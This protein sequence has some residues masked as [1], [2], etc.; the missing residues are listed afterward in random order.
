MHYS[1]Y[2]K[3]NGYVKT[4][5]PKPPFQT[6]QT[7]TVVDNLKFDDASVMNIPFEPA[8]PKPEPKKEY[9]MYDALASIP[10]QVEQ[11][12]PSQFPT[13]DPRT[14]Q[15]PNVKSNFDAQSDK[16]ATMLDKVSNLLE[17][18]TEPPTQLNENQVNDILEY[19]EHLQDQYLSD[20]PISNDLSKPFVWN[21]PMTLYEDMCEALNNE[22]PDI[23]NPMFLFY[24]TM[25]DYPGLAMGKF[26][27]ILLNLAYDHQ[28][29]I[30]MYADQYDK[31]CDAVENEDDDPGT[32]DVTEDDA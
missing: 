21:I 28:N 3:T 22:L 8:D 20:L 15:F 27:K 32:L 31:A 2:L 19:M 23:L 29:E 10:V 16:L 14:Y 24:I 25:L 5:E 12:D 30:N 18:C 1:Y 26:M 9:N 6:Q 7:S 17:K 11:I 13:V 4:V